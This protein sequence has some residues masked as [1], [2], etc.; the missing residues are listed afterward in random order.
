MFD[1]YELN[2]LIHRE[3]YDRPGI[4]L[5]SGSKLFSEQ[6]IDNNCNQS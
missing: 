2:V 6:N 5:T 1:A 4:V 3:N